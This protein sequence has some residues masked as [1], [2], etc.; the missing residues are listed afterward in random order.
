MKL[1][2]FLFNYFIKLIELF[3]CYSIIK[4]FYLIKL[5]NY[6]TVFI[7]FQWFYWINW[8]ISFLFN[9]L[10]ELIELFDFYSIIQWL[11]HEI[12][13]KLMN[14]QITKFYYFYSMIIL[15]N[16]MINIDMNESIKWRFWKFELWCYLINNSWQWPASRNLW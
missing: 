5:S 9:Y 6:S 1:F 8:I 3:Y 14:Y 2:S 10:N 11:N 12:L 7:Y 4:S 16:G 15:L 13:I